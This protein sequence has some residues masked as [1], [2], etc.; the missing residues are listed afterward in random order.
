MSLGDRIDVS[1]I[2]AAFLT[3]KFSRL[4]RVFEPGE[5]QGKVAQ[6]YIVD[7]ALDCAT[8]AV[9]HHHHNL[10]TRHS[11]SELDRAQN[12]VVDGIAG[13]AAVKRLAN[14]N[15]ADHL[16]GCPAVDARKENS[17]RMLTF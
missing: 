15:I 11:C 16:N 12:V 2:L 13:H 9:P 3:C 4:Y 1:R 6:A 7:R 8:S 10:G 17:G 14:S 5:K